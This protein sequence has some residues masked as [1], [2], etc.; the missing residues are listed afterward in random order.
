MALGVYRGLRFGIVLQPD[1]P[2]EV[3]LEGATTRHERLART[4]H[5]PRA[6]FNALDRLCNAYGNDIARVHQDLS[7]TESQL[8]DYQARIDKP[9]TH[10][11]YQ[12]ELMQLRYMLKASLARISH[13]VSSPHFSPSVATIGFRGGATAPAG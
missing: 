10:D 12:T 13:Q 6:V 5:G 4:S 3:Y 8:R 11:A 7:I 2:P 9:F 1:F